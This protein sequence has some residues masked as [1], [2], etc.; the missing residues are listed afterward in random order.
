MLPLTLPLIPPLWALDHTSTILSNINVTNHS[1]ILILHAETNRFLMITRQRP[2]QE[3]GRASRLRAKPASSNRH[4]CLLIKSS[5]PPAWSRIFFNSHSV[6]P[7]HLLHSAHTAFSLSS[8]RLST[9]HSYPT[10]SNFNTLLPPSDFSLSSSS[11]CNSELPILQCCFCAFVT[12][13]PSPSPSPM[14]SSFSDAASLSSPKF[15]CFDPSS[16]IENRNHSVTVRSIGVVPSDGS[17]SAKQQQ[18][19][20]RGECGYVLEDVPHLTDYLPDLRVTLLFFVS[21]FLALFNFV[22]YV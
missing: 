14:A 21:L 19:I 9:C 4:S 18:K 5:F 6:S 22:I 8:S 11:Y 13:S 1:Q 7:A 17:D 20:I 16:A 15:R 2:N 10:Y 3:K 12:Q